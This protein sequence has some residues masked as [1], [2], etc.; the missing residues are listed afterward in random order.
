VTGLS[1]DAISPLEVKKKLDAGENLFLLDVREPWEVEMA[2][3]AGAKVIPTYELAQ[4]VQEIPK[5]REV[6]VIC[7]V[8]ARSMMSAYYLR[9]LGYT[10]VKNMAGGIDLWSDEVDPSVPKYE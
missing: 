8:G 5:D 3:I 9:R 1:V 2:S 6:I 7:H 4:R 10:K